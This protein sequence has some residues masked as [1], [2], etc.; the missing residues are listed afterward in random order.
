MKIIYTIQTDK[1]SSFIYKL[2]NFH[3]ILN[4]Y[5]LF[6]FKHYSCNFKQIT[7]YTLYGFDKRYC[8]IDRLVWNYLWA[9]LIVFE[10]R[11]ASISKPTSAGWGLSLECSSNIVRF[12]RLRKWLNDYEKIKQAQKPFHFLILEQLFTR[13]RVISTI[14]AKTFEVTITR[15][16]DVTIW[17][18]DH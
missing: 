13:I 9:C 7:R 14:F 1:C 18:N 6:I 8:L 5:L 15:T 10:I 16:W 12:A 3:C 4:R 2:Y 17:R 11:Q